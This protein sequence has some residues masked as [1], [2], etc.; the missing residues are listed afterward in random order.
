MTIW[1]SCLL[2]AYLI[3]VAFGSWMKFLNLEYLKKHGHQIPEPFEGQ[4][5]GDLLKKTSDYT[6][7]HSR[8]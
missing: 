2:V 4:I 1:M 3:S 6:F 8:F 7:Q 5:D